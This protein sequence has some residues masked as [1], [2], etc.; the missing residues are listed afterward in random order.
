MKDLL[1]RHREHIA[2]DERQAIW[3]RVRPAEAQAHRVITIRRWSL[4]FGMAAIAVAL[5]AVIITEHNRDRATRTDGGRVV[6]VPIG[7]GVPSGPIS[8]D[9]LRE[10]A[11]SRSMDG[12][13]Y[14]QGSRPGAGP[15][16]R[17]Q[18]DST[19]AFALVVGGDSF[20]TAKKYI[21]EGG[22]PPAG[23]VRIEEFVNALEQGYPD[24]DSPDLRLFVDG[25]PSPFGDRCQL[26]RV[27]LKARSPASGDSVEIIARGASVE[28]TF[29]PLTVAQYRLIGFEKKGVRPGATSKGAA[30]AA[31]YEVAALYEVKLARRS[32]EA[33]LLDVRVR[34]EQPRRSE[35]KGEEEGKSSA[36]A[37]SAGEGDGRLTEI[38]ASFRAADL[39][40]MFA[41]APARF[42]LAAA[43][44]EFA[45][46]L[47]GLPWTKEHRLREVL[48]MAE[49]LATELPND[50]RIRDFAILVRRAAEI[51]GEISGATPGS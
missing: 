51:R 41:L 3:R 15:F 23:D 40:P 48:L 30:I 4:S 10:V 49:G 44:A 38:A 27:G 21:E 8:P 45:E 37:P 26:V 46:I 47:R 5:V 29:D 35:V 24:F 36:A 11:F 9:Q 39:N 28:V 50:A 2:P 42:R 17:A 12:G 22:L 43:S 32:S 34:Y 25:A 14:E 16:V 20:V 7:T 31:G 1:D 19:S 13:V 18:D 33:K 6:Q